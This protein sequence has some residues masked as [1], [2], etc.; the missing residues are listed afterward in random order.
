MLTQDR[1]PYLFFK[2]I[3][4]SCSIHID[5]QTVW[6]S[7]IADKFI[8]GSAFLFIA[9][10]IGNIF[11]YLFQLSMGRMLT[12]EAYGEMNALL[13]LMVIFSIPFGT[14]IN[15][16]ARETAVYSNSGVDGLASIKGLHKFGLTKTCLFMLPILGFLGL[17]SSSI[18]EYLEVS[19]DKVLLTLVCVFTAALVTVN[20]GVIQGMQYFRGLSFIGAGASIFKFTFAVF[21]VWIGWGV[22]GAIGGVFATGLTLWAFSQWLI[23]SSLPD[24]TN[25][26]NISSK[27]IITYGGALFLANSLFAIM[28]QADVMLVKH[29]FPPQEA[30][31]YASAAIM[32]KAVMYLPG[33][34]VMALFPMVAANQANGQSSGALLA[35]SLSLTFALSGT[36]AIILFLFPEWIM[37]VLFGDRYLSAASITSI[38]GLS[39]LPMALVFLLMNFL[40]AQGKT[41]FVGFM[42]VAAA[43][44]LAGIHF[45][46]NNIHNV[47]YVI[48]AAG[49][50]ALIPMAIL[51]LFQ[52]FRL[53][54]STDNGKRILFHPQNKL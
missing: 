19:Y 15:F 42:A 6:R 9:M 10:V 2:K 32:G 41:G 14:L 17:L 43:L 53:N 22:H 20:T 5:F 37:G 40:I 49:Y 18:G 48:M 51:L 8:K 26:F 11:A 46:I 1:Q 31:L 39:M 25:P 4:R 27:E 36:G 47:L 21:F 29:Y 24:R 35:K 38:F 33:A 28:T 44:E 16:F 3:I 34:I 7:V 45:F 52:L 54:K 50:I 13:S 30:G 23:L 12:I